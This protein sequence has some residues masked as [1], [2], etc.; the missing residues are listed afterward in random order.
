MP[1]GDAVAQAD[2]PALPLWG[3]D[4]LAQPVGEGDMVAP[5]DGEAREE[6]EP[7]SAVCDTDGG[8]L[9]DAEGVL[10]ESGVAVPVPVAAAEAEAPADVEQQ[11]DDVG[12]GGCEPLPQ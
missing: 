11:A 8:A 6:G 2:V 10:D 3:A 12:E 4:A 5:I 7:G 1:P 9:N